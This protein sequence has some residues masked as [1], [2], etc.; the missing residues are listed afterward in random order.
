M[1]FHKASLLLWQCSP[2]SNNGYALV[3]TNGYKTSGCDQVQLMMCSS[4]KHV[5]K[6]I[7]FSRCSSEVQLSLSFGLT[8]YHVLL[9][10]QLLY[11]FRTTNGG[12]RYLSAINSPVHD[13]T[14][15]WDAPARFV[16]LIR[17]HIRVSKLTVRLL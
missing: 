4:G 12:G 7:C 13:M 10:V 2:T 1:N 6:C 17:I 5:W 11:E 8:C 14:R 9:E 16:R 15:L 3:H